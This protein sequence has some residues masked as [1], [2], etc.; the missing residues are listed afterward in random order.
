MSTKKRSRPSPAADSAEAE[1]DDAALRKA[2]GK[3]TPARSK[4]PFANGGCL[5]AL[6]QTTAPSVGVVTLFSALAL[7]Y[8]IKNGPMLSEVAQS[9]LEPW[10]SSTATQ[11][12]RRRL[13]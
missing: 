6:T 12:R 8:Y 13:P 2:M 4:A 7:N 3:K 1:V 9:C 11:H 10:T 5:G